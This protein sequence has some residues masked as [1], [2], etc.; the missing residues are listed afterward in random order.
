MFFRHRTKQFPGSME[1]S[2]M[3]HHPLEDRTPTGVL[4][5]IEG[6]RMLDSL[7]EERRAAGLARL[8]LMLDGVLD[9]LTTADGTMGEE[10]SG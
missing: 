7:D 3:T 10:V 9:R 8:E 4:R 5:V 1:A 6:G 2:Q